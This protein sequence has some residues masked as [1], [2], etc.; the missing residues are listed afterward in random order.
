MLIQS[1]KLII[2]IYTINWAIKINILSILMS[3]IKWLIDFYQTLNKL[4]RIRVKTKNIWW[5]NSCYWIYLFVKN[6]T[7]KERNL[8]KC[9]VLYEGQKL[10]L[11]GFKSEILDQSD[12]RDKGSFE[13]FYWLYSRHY[14]H[15]CFRK[16][17]ICHK[18]TIKQDKNSKY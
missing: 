9:W 3:V 6:V 14:M 15:A 2:Q 13:E 5:F 16:I 8:K 4:W 11:N 12:T 18:K 10:I 17:R 1:F 7:K